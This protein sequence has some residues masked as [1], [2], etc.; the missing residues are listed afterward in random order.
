MNKITDETCNSYIADSNKQCTSQSKCKYCTDNEC[1]SQANSK[2][3][4]VFYYGNLA[5]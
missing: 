5:T 2:V 1:T 4:D 3:Y